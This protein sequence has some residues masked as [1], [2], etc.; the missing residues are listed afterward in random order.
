MKLS[1]RL[2]IERAYP[3]LVDHPLLT[4]DRLR[5]PANLLPLVDLLYVPAPRNAEEELDDPPEVDGGDALGSA[6]ARERQSDGPTAEECHVTQP[7]LR[8]G[9]GT[10]GNLN[11]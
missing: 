11:G 1:R 8:R 9:I 4:E 7:L 6:H 2:R 10:L 5:E 3:V